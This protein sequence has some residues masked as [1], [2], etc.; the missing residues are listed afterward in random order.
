MEMSYK[1][2][3]DRTAGAWA[4][5]AL[6]SCVWHLGWP[7]QA[8]GSHRRHLSPQTCLAGS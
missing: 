6:R 3:L 5:A 7:E 4:E 8:R 2:R 1:E